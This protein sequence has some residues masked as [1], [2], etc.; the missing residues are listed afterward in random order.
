[1]SG[2]SRSR[3]GSGQEY[4]GWSSRIRNDL[5]AAIAPLRRRDD[6]RLF[7]RRRRV[8]DRN[9]FVRL[10]AAQLSDRRKSGGRHLLRALRR[11][12]RHDG[13]QAYVAGIRVAKIPAHRSH[14]PA[15]QHSDRACHGQDELRLARRRR[16]A[17][18][19]ASH[20]SNDDAGADGGVDTVLRDGVL[21]RGHRRAGRPQAAVSLRRRLRRRDGPPRARPDIRVPRKPDHLRV[22]LWR[23]AVVPAALPA[24]GLVP[25]R[26]AR[27]HWLQPAS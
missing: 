1:M 12:H 8:V 9:A 18:S 19:L 21:R 22:H 2:R 26:S 23:G 5:V 7:P 16:D 10:A 14:V 3:S 24:R 6:G 25:A 4:D 17:V 27:P 13:A 15:H 11:D 20:R